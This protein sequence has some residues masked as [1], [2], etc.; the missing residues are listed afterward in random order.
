MLLG[1]AALGLDPVRFAAALGFTPDPWQADALRSTAPRVLLNVTRQGGKSLV[2]AVLALHQALYVPRS[3]AL[4]ISPS[5]RQSAELYRR[6]R[7]LAASLPAPPRM[8]ED[9]ATSAT[10][11]NGSR[12]ISLPSSEPTIRGYSSVDL[13][14]EDEASRVP[15]P[16]Y[17]ATRPML[18]VSGGRQ[19]LLS[20]PFGRRGHFFEAWQDEDGWER[21]EVPAT[22]VP[23]I[24]AAFLEGERRAMGA[25]W[26]GQEY[27]CQFS[28]SAGQV[29][30]TEDVLAAFSDSIVPLFDRM[31]G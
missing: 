16:L 6:V 31:S 30:R 12:V 17:Y 4:V 26:F 20:T 22:Q 8:T 24:P 14:I 25:W 2:A 28:D 23:R 5:L 13:L 29:F 11:A 18:A 15:D 9:T 21:Y 10:L 19:L 7:E 27:L 3:L 1:D